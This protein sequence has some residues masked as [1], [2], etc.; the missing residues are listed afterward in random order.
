MAKVRLVKS[1]SLEKKRAGN[2][3]P[4][5]KRDR[6]GARMKT[7]NQMRLVVRNGKKL[8]LKP[9]IARNLKTSHTRRREVK[10]LTA[11]SSRV[12]RAEAPRKGSRV[13]HES[14]SRMRR[15]STRSESKATTVPS[16]AKQENQNSTRVIKTW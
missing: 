3:A 14:I 6:N 12:L 10:M 1:K 7:A 15:G 4:K 11:C 16:K 5:A 9:L 2:K 13:T 8:L